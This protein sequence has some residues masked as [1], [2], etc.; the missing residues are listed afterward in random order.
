[1]VCSRPQVALRPKASLFQPKQDVSVHQ[2][3]CGEDFKDFK[4]SFE[5]FRGLLPAL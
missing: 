2:A 4:G 1:M 5:M 3:V